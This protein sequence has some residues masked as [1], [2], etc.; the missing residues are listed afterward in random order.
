[1][2]N[3][4]FASTFATV[5]HMEMSELR[6]D[7]PINYVLELVGD[8]WSLLILRDLIFDNKKSYSDFLTSQEKIATNIL[9]S[10][11]TRLED[12]GF[13]QKRPGS[14]NKA[15]YTYVLTPMSIDLVP[16]FIEMILWSDKYS[17]IPV[18]PERQDDLR[19]VKADKQ[20]FIA[21]VQERLR[22]TDAEIA[23]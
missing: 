6:S 17:S 21:E 20:A 11:L 3:L 8:R 14:T 22:A 19:K 10:R 7:C 5:I 12:E 15:R 9:A 2:A 1:M 4:H 13:I 18:P 16:M 23:L